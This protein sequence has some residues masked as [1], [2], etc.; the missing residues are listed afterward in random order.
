MGESSLYADFFFLFDD[1][2]EVALPIRLDGKLL[3]VKSG[4]PGSLFCELFSEFSSIIV[5]RFTKEFLPNINGSCDP[6]SM[7]ILLC[8]GAH[9]SGDFLMISISILQLLIGQKN[10]TLS[11]AKRKKTIFNDTASESSSKSE[12]GCGS[13]S[14]YDNED[15]TVD[16]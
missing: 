2:A 13:E 10:H 6:S 7:L 16:M 1:L 11:E 5:S 14:F 3:V 8:D 15:F 12:S 4:M 9:I